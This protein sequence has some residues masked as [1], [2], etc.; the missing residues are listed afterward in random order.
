MEIEDQAQAEDTTGGDEMI[1]SSTLNGS[2]EAEAVPTAHAPHDTHTHTHTHVAGIAVPSEGGGTS[3]DELLRILYRDYCPP[4]SS[5]PTPTLY[6]PNVP[7]DYLGKD[8][9]IQL[10]K[11]ANCIRCI[12]EN[13]GT[14]YYFEVRNLYEAGK[15]LPL[16]QKEMRVSYFGGKSIEVRLRKCKAQL[17]RLVVAP[18]DF[19]PILCLNYVESSASVD[20]VRS[21]FEHFGAVEDVE[22]VELERMEGLFE[23]FITYTDPASAVKGR[24]AFHFSYYDGRVVTVIS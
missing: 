3:S 12:Q 4:R 22:R 15:V 8:G 21:D 13:D 2:I 14:E 11:K 24:N 6:I 23:V 9:R 10:K 20:V 5:A 1:I 18:L 19:S 7:K 17:E 16:L